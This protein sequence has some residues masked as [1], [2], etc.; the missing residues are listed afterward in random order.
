MTNWDKI[1]TG[2]ELKATKRF[3]SRAYIT[4]KER[5]VALGDLIE[6][7]WEEFKSYKDKKW[8]GV[9]RDK[10]IGEIF[11]DKVWILFANLGFT[12]M[13]ANS[14]FKIQYESNNESITQQIDVFAADDE[15]VIIVECKAANELKDGSFKKDIEAFYGQMEG[16]RKDVLKKYPGRK[17]KFIWA[18]HNIT[19]NRADLN[20]LDEWRIEHFNTTTIEYYSDLVKHLGTS[21]KY[22]LLGRLFANQGIK[23]M[24][25]KIPA[26]QGKMGGNI[27]YSFSIEPE[28]L[29]KIGYVLHRNE[30][31][32]NMMPTY[33]RLIKKSR[34]SGVK[35]FVSGGGYF[36]NSVIISIDTDGKGLQ[37][38]PASVKFETSISKLGTLHLPKKYRSA[39]IIDGQHRLYGYSDSPYASTNT[40][41]V[42][43]FIDLDR[44]EQIKLFKEINENQKAV[45]KALRVTL[46]ADLLWVSSDFNEQRQALRSRVALMLAEEEASPLY[47]RIVTGEDEKTSIMCITIEAVQQALKK[48]DFFTKFDRRNNI[49][50][51]G[52]FDLGNNDATCK[53]FYPF[54]EEC[55]C[56]IE[57]HLEEEWDKADNENGLLTVNRGI[58]AVIRLLNDI[59]NH[60]FEKGKITP[61]DDKIEKILQEVKFYI[62]PFITFLSE[63]TLEER[64]DLRS[65]LGG[66][67][68]IKFL[69]R[70]QKAVADTRHDFCPEGLTEYWIDEAKTFNDESSG[71]LRDIEIKLKELI[72]I[73]LEEK[74]KE[75]W[76]VHGLPKAIYIKAK[77]ESDDHSYDIIASGGGEVLT[78]WDCVPFAN[79]KQI[80][81]YGSHWSEIFEN[82]LTRPED[83]N[84][85]RSK[86]KRTEWIT[87][88]GTI[89]NKLKNPSYSASREEYDFISGINVW[90]QETINL[91]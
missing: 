7:G 32:K 20:K 75:N 62:D 46:D 25:G 44:K 79:L 89:K 56:Y 82:I 58:Q 85:H 16:I 50:K 13:N 24:E 63:I 66:G 14:D 49:T 8:I 29:L 2:S 65:H 60:L 74:Y 40:I 76:I 83:K 45:P 38:D 61:K 21:A 91:E 90:L 11:E 88:L 18:T 34:L 67:A 53:L 55:L 54:L 69:R 42:V 47:G 48:C 27:Y 64:K 77:K 23:N 9:K 59:V 78:I 70:F 37:F 72:S 31:N 22:Q 84:V 80:A 51:D 39:Y 10:P 1:V 68:D 43:A 73:N 86:D 17:V 19:M 3:R 28:K 57:E 41:P 6:E 5:R 30:A 36:P 4:A 81:I 71:Y 52:T 35:S 26:I 87:R 12:D 33:Q 15:T